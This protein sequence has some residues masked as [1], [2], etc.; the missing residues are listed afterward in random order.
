[1]CSCCRATDAA[2][3]LV[4]QYINAKEDVD[5]MNVLR[6]F[7]YFYYK[8]VTKGLYRLHI[9]LTCTDGTLCFVCVAE[10]PCH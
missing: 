2:N 3:L 1:M 8:E 9:S 6:L 4:V 5:K 7:D 10:D